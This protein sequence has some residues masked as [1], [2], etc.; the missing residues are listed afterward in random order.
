MSMFSEWIRKLVSIVMISSFIATSGPVGAF[1]MTM[2]PDHLRARSAKQSDVSDKVL[3]DLSQKDGG[4]ADLPSDAAKLNF[5]DEK[6]VLAAAKGILDIYADKVVVLDEKALVGGLV[7]KL[8]YDATFSKDQKVQSLCRRLIKDTAAAQGCVLGSVYDLYSKKAQDKRRYT[9]PAIN[10]RGMAYNTARAAFSSAKKHNA[11]FIAE[12]AKSEIGYTNQRPAELATSI[13][14]AAIKEGYKSTVYIQ[15]DHFQMDQK[16]YAKNADQAREDV[17]KLIREAIEAG[18]YQ[19]DLDMSTLV[20]FSKTSYDEQQKLN[21]TETAILT[22]YVR[23]LEKEFGLNKKGIVVNLGA[24][25]GEIGKGLEKGKERN[26]S[27]EDLE[28]FW[29]GYINTLNDLGKGARLIPAT[30]I[31]I[32]TGTKHG[33]IRGKDGKLAKAKVSFN[34]I[35]ELGKKAR[36]LGLAGVVQHG[37]STLDPE[38][39][40]IFAGNEATGFEVGEDLLS[41][42]AK[43]VIGE[44]PTAEVHLATAYQDTVMDHAAMPAALLV[45][46]KAFIINKVQ[47]AADANL[48]GVFVDNRKTCWGPFKT[49]LWNLDESIQSQFRASLEK[50]FDVVF[51][52]LGAKNTQKIVKDLNKPAGKAKKEFV[53]ASYTKLD[54]KAGINVLLNTVNNQLYLPLTVKKE[55]RWGRPLKDAGNSIAD[56]SLISRDP[57]REMY[58]GYRNVAMEGDKELFAGNKNLRF[59]ITVLYPGQIG[60]EL[61]MTK[62]H[63]HVATAAGDTYGEIYEVWSGKALYLQQGYNAQGEFEVLATFANPGD[64]IIMLPTYSHRTVNIGTEPLV[65]ANWMHLEVNGSDTRPA[66]KKTTVDFS[67]IEAKNGYAYQVIKTTDGTIA[68]RENSKWPKAKVRFAVPAAQIKLTDDAILDNKVPMYGLLDKGTVLEDFLKNAKGFDKV[69]TDAFVEISERDALN[70]HNTEVLKDGGVMQQEKAT[71]LDID[72]AAIHNRYKDLDRQTGQWLDLTEAEMKAVLVKLGTNPDQE[73][74][75]QISQIVHNTRP[76]QV[77]KMKALAAEPN[78]FDLARKLEIAL[79]PVNIGVSAGNALIFRAGAFGLF[80]QQ[81]FQRGMKI[82]WIKGLSGKKPF[83]AKD[84]VQHNT[85]YGGAFTPYRIEGM[86]LGKPVELKNGKM[87]DTLIIREDKNLGRDKQTIYYFGPDFDWDQSFEAMEE[88]G[89]KTDVVAEYGPGKEEGGKLQPNRVKRFI[90]RGW[91]VVAASPINTD[92][93]RDMLAKEGYTDKQALMEGLYSANR[94]A[95]G[96]KTMIVDTLTC[97]SNAMI[98]AIY[99]VWVNFGIINGTGLTVHS[100]TDSNAHFPEPSGRSR[101]LVDYLRGFSID[102]DIQPAGTG[103]AKNLIKMVKELKT[104]EGKPS[105]FNI[106]AYRTGTKSGSAFDITINIKKRATKEE[107]VEAFRTFARDN[108]DGVME[109][110]N[111]VAS[112]DWAPMDTNG[113]VGNPHVSIIDNLFGIEVLADD[114]TAVDG[115]CGTIRIMGLYD[116]ES[117]APNQIVSKWAPWVVNGMKEREINKGA[118]EVHGTPALLKNIDAKTGA[119]VA[120]EYGAFVETVKAAKDAKGALVVGA[121]ALMDNAG[122]LSSLKQVKDANPG[123]KVVVWANGIFEA[124][125]LQAMKV[126]MIADGITDKGLRG[127]FATVEQLGVP[128][129]RV[130]LINSAI[131]VE[132]IK[133]EYAAADLSAVLAQKQGVKAVSVQAPDMKAAAVNAMPLVVARAVTGAMADNTAV[134]ASYQALGKSLVDNDAVAPENLKALDDLTKDVAEAPLVKVSDE[135]VKTHI[136]YQETLNK[137]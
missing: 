33:G 103:A 70:D 75:N 7:D 120:K 32:Q 21:Y 47:P 13:L 71:K 14:A 78:P 25:I 100:E 135:M 76:E 11:I 1:A 40:V 18:F 19:I 10:F 93:L 107:V 112:K 122:L 125:K 34:T 62:G 124:A 74:V 5:T 84:L 72:F 50:Q 42:A 127:A 89:I 137:I 8:V 56:P 129:N 39:F 96:E 29:K 90:E 87:V 82:T 24:E 73:T 35:A 133:T 23:G 101:D 115:T 64:K 114:Q 17:K 102:N 6:S 63:K 97:T 132:N 106:K 12:I 85:R 51:Q 45:N 98:S 60:D 83:T 88:L 46:M 67:E 44:N 95:I 9:I 77:E 27:I 43:I 37:A 99:V 81:N 92:G 79:R 31:A 117:A 130:S 123:I 111:G 86:E 26:S 55:N 53:F 69:F 38:C 49:Q 134:V 105:R 59:D 104:E 65:M 108:S 118:I 54:D 126:D 57:N 28:A 22:Q 15:G 116:N 121:N 110:Y 94:Q 16:A 119:T 80:M 3:K 131:D 128:Q 30:K 41:S 48:N 36:E 68:L 58:Y 66:A 61:V 20:D 91:R 2:R 4:A 113:I 136:A 52:N 109:F